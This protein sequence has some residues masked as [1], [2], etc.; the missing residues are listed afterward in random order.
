VELDWTWIA[1]TVCLT[2]YNEMWLMAC[3]YPNM[4]A[5]QDIEHV[6]IHEHLLIHLACNMPH[7]HMPGHQACNVRTSPI[8]ITC[9][10]ISAKKI[11]WVRKQIWDFQTGSRR[12][13]LP[14]KSYQQLIRHNVCLLWYLLKYMSCLTTCKSLSI[15]HCSRLD[16]MKLIQVTS[17]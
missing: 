8:S 7:D 13:E 10:L 6:A 5:F 15:I 11:V 3:M 17:R 9:M 1:F 14:S 2:Y 16:N 4:T 12:Q